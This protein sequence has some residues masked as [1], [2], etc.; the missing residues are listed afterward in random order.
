MIAILIVLVITLIGFTVWNLISLKELKKYNRSKQEI[1]D[2]RYYELKYRI[3][4]ITTIGLIIISIGAFF[5]Y[6]WF[7]EIKKDASDNLKSE[8]EK[9][10][11][12]IKSLYSEMEYTDST[13][14][15]YQDSVAYYKKSVG[16]IIDKQNVIDYKADYSR[17]RFNQLSEK[18]DV[19]NNKNC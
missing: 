11:I 16:D 8:T 5:G 7:E 1:K 18:I 13:I 2:D 6:K 4:Y 12:K 10:E 15:S 3:E 14:K 19:I 9:F 17:D